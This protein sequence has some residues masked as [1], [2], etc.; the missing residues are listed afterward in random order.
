MC[1]AGPSGD[2]P[3]SMCFARADG[4]KNPG[5][6]PVHQ[7]R[8][9]RDV[10][11]SCKAAANM[12]RKIQRAPASP[13]PPNRARRHETPRSNASFETKHRPPA[14]FPELLSWEQSVA[15]E[16]C[17]CENKI[18]R[19]FCSGRLARCLREECRRHACPTVVIPLGYAA[20]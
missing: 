15:Y 4:R 8:N 12:L 13:R 16:T 10:E 3:G 20:A 9:D 18:A 1:E 6:G 2:P 7:R 17:F 5:P 11:E 14:E 19:R